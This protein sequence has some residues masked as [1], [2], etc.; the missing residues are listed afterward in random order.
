M[1]CALR[2]PAEGTVGSV[3]HSQHPLGGLIS[4]DPDVAETLTLA[5]L[6]HVT[7]G[8]A[9]FHFVMLET[10]VKLHV[11]C[12]LWHPLCFAVVV[13]QFQLRRMSLIRNFQTVSILEFN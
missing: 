9:R 4:V 11:D 7:L 3:G 6:R 1:G 12:V 13:S 2:C 8:A 10:D 5:G